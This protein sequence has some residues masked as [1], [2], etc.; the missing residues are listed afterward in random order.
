MT[1]PLVEQGTVGDAAVQVAA[2]AH[3]HRKLDAVKW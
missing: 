2:S 1:I 3:T